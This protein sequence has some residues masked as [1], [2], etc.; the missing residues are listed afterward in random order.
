MK[1]RVTGR[2]KEE[3]R[4]REKIFHLLVHFPNGLMVRVEPGAWNSIQISHIGSWDP[5]TWAIFHCLPRQIN[6][7][8]D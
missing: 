4:E 1:G 5:S 7:K 2:G 8:L 6:R 3:G